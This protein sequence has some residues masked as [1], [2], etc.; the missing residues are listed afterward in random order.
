LAR[1]EE[2]TEEQRVIAESTAAAISAFQKARFADAL[3]Q[4][5]RLEAMTGTDKLILLYRQLCEAYL[6]DPPQN[7]CGQVV[8][9]EK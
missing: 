2:A 4:L 7:F 3:V 5:G 1:C 6:L 8:L 9:S